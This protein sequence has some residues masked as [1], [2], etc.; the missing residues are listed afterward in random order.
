MTTVKQKKKVYRPYF[1]ISKL[2]IRLT[3]NFR[4]H[5][6]LPR[7]NEQRDASRTKFRDSQLVKRRVKLTIDKHLPHRY[8]RRPRGTATS[9]YRAACFRGFSIIRVASGPRNRNIMTFGVSPVVSH[10]P[11][12]KLI[13]YAFGNGAGRAV[14]PARCH[15]RPSRGSILDNG[16]RGRLIE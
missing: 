4:Y 15:A 2:P 9:W 11:L 13:S 7:K 14:R 8:I 12:P 6:P 1:Y 10:L 5:S 3:I 16:P